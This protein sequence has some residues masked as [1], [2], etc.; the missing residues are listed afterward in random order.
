MGFRARRGGVT[1]A[2]V[3]ITSMLVALLPATPIQAAPG[4]PFTLT[5][6]HHN[7]GESQL[8]AAPGES[9]FGGVARFKTLADALKAA[10]DTGPDA[11]WVMLTSGD[12]F[13][14]GPELAASFAGTDFYDALALRAIGYDAMVIGNHDFDFGPDFLER[15]VTEV[16]GGTDTIPF[17]SANLD[18]S[19]E[20]GLAALEAAGLVASST[21]VSRDGRDIGIIGATTE[22]L[23]FIS[24]PRDVV[25]NAV[26]TAVQ[27]EIDALT[28]AGVDIIILS[29]HLQGIEEDVALIA[30]LDGID[31]AIAG[32]GDELLSNPGDLLVPGDSPDGRPYPLMATDLGGDSVPIVTTA[33]DYKYIGRLVVTFDGSGVVT[34]IDPGS[35][36]VRVSGVDADAVVE[37]TAVQTAVTGPV[38]A[39]VAALD[40][41]VLATSEV[42]LDGRRAPGVRTKE[43]NEGNLIADAFL[44][45]ANQLAGA[46]GLGTVD[47]ALANGGGIRNNN[48]I[49]AGDISELDTFDMLPFSNFLSVFETIPRDQFKLIMENA[50]SRAEGGSGTGRFAQIA[51]FTMVFDPLATPLAVDS[52]GVV[53]DPGS[54]VESIVLSDGTV[55]VDDGAVV[56]GPDI[57]LTIVDFLARGGDQYPFMGAPF[58]NLGVSY[59]QALF[60]YL[61]A[62][63]GDGGLD[64]VI[65]AADYPEGGEG[66]IVQAL[67]INEFVSNHTGSDTDEFVEVLGIPETD[68]SEYTVL[69]IEGEAGSKGRI[70]Q[71]YTVGATNADGYW[72][73]GPGAIELENGTQTLL[74]VKHFSGSV[75]DDID[76]DDDGVIDNAPWGA[77]VDGVAVADATADDLTY[78]DTVLTQGFDG[79]TFTVGGASRIPDGTDTGTVGDWVRN[80]FGGDG[81]PSFP[82]ATAPLGAAYNTPGAANAVQDADIVILTIPEIQGAGHVSPH[83]GEIAQTEG[84]V[85]AVGFNGF[86][87]QD[88]TG[89]GDDATSDG[90]FVFTGGAPTVAAGDQVRVTGP[91]SEFIPGGAASGNL[92][93]SQM[94]GDVEVFSSGNPLPA[95]V[96]I[97]L[98][99]RVP[100]PEIVISSDEVPVNLQT[101]P[102]LFDPDEDAIDFFEAM[103]AMLVVV[104]SPQAVSATRT[105]NA[106]SSE[107]FS[108]PNNGDALIVEPDDALTSRGGIELQPDADNT[109]DQN[110]ERVQIQ[111]DG[112]LYPGAVPLL[113]VGDRLDDVTG[114]VGYSFGNYEVNAT[115]A[116][117]VL[118]GSGLTAE[119]TALGGSDEDVTVASYN[120]LNLSSD[121]SDDAQRATIAGHVV[122]NLGAPDV[123]ALQ[124]IQ[125]NSGEVDDGVT[126]A[127]QTLQAL[128]DAISDAGGP[129]YAFVDVA[130]ADG[131]SGGVP[132]GNIRNSFLYNPDRV[133]LVD[134]ESLTDIPAFAGTRDPLVATFSFN[135][136]E[137][138]VVN[139][140]LTSR[141]G[142][143]PIFGG[144]QPFVQAGEAEREAQ[145]QALND[146][147]DGLLAADPEA[148]VIVAG[149][150][151]TFQW[152]DDIAE[153]LPG[154][155]GVLTNLVD[156]LTD[157]AVYSYIFD[158]NSQQL[159]HLLVSDSLLSGAE[160]D[161]VHVNVDF[162]RVDASTASDH[163]PLLAKLSLPDVTPPMVTAELDKQWASPWAGVFTV[164]YSCTDD[165]ALASCEG[166]LNGIPVADGQRVF[167]LRGYGRG[168]VRTIKGTLYIKAPH[169]ELEVTGIDTSGNE[170][171][172]TDRPEFR[173]H[174]FWWWG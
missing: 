39:F 89:D 25:V 107:F 125:D 140:H 6:L 124:E 110:P 143:T 138:T 54:R 81:L 27:A 40:A 41:N 68:Y 97:G 111:F 32:G 109:G 64:G 34:S 1:A 91:V 108:V 131:A 79:G 93:T 169:F 174:W 9:D 130:P 4:D 83:A 62:D 42:S 123:I 8:I 21:V 44:W 74:L 94:G 133:A 118:S 115:E 87:L 78:T 103:E 161:I 7:D 57:S 139:N 84:V 18:L 30:E 2:L 17:L 38:A 20:P 102:G 66:R 36:P 117:T 37:D 168:F 147:V 173:R 142:S 151:N 144:P 98:G 55:I 75:G 165:V 10:A 100:P 72:V 159:D 16:N 58:T 12:N 28:L 82:L 11:D 49:P 156:T 92:S 160:F 46:F 167:L 137:F 162:P 59:Q 112:T 121:T 60:N 152:T 43:T 23:P 71:A 146:Y 65:A 13:L 29:A 136:N 128:I 45:Q 166:E 153:I 114:V 22:N 85:T 122:D 77:L 53:T 56:A 171:T 31:V 164:V 96:V 88:P 47:V 127:D 120:V 163:E 135:G 5:I 155:E 106:F 113:T 149:D 157:D 116:V 26:K 141:F 61:T 90:I 48:V 67:R 3:A 119:V 150:M 86:Y 69:V 70:D 50:V 14:A 132:G 104:E 154:P 24:S 129:T 105:F 134:F 80:D 76:G 148:K 51:G 15:F 158:G 101:D 33:G 172:V 63:S 170:T 19:G 126:A 35:G 99:G 95:P 52:D 73:E 145:F